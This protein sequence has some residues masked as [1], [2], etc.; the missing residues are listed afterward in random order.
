[1]FEDFYPVLVSF[2]MK[3]V[4]TTSFPLI[5]AIIITRQL[6]LLLSANCRLHKNPPAKTLASGFYY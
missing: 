1:M 2:S 3:T 6:T 5:G 4:L